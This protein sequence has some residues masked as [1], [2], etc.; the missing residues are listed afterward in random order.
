MIT[1]SDCGTIVPGAMPN[2][3]RCGGAVDARSPHTSSAP[4]PTGAPGSTAAT[5]SG[6][7]P[8]TMTYPTTVGADTASG[9]PS[10][11]DWP[12]R[13][14]TTAVPAYPSPGL[15]GTPVI[16]GIA[17]RSDWTGI[18]GVVAF[19]VSIVCV[20]AWA[21]IIYGIII[22]IVGNAFGD[23]FTTSSSSDYC[24]YWD[25]DC[26]A[27]Q[28]AANGVVIAGIVLA[29]IGLILLISVI[30]LMR[31]SRGGQVFC[32]AIQVLLIILSV[33]SGAQANEPAVTVV[34]AVFPAV[35]LLCIASG[36]ANRLIDSA[37]MAVRAG[38]RR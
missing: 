15:P 38:L 24:D 12:G 6:F 20:Q 35:A 29:A 27:A 4:A 36:P 17:P 10:G 2:C 31:G 8:P 13:P 23:V 34:G 11:S 32:C 19:G 1:C 33:V 28:S 22:A 5:S 30:A 9:Y 14:P 25:T 3:P 26:Q 16:A 18:P 21:A 7:P 37:T